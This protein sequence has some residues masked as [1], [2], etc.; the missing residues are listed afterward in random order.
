MD[1]WKQRVYNAKVIGAR[2][3]SW[4]K[5]LVGKTVEVV[6]FTHN[7]YLCVDRNDRTYH[8]NDVKL[9]KEVRQR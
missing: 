7:Y 9:G 5:D 6:K 1:E 4:Y 3:G 2:P 8:V